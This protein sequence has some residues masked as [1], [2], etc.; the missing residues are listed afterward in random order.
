M[1]RRTKSVIRGRLRHR[2][3][4]VLKSSRHL[5]PAVGPAV[6]TGSLRRGSHG[7]HRWEHLRIRAPTRRSISVLANGKFLSTA[8]R[9]DGGGLARLVSA[10]PDVS[11][12]RVFGLNRNTGSAASRTAA[13]DCHIIAPFEVLGPAGRGLQPPSNSALSTICQ[14]HSTAAIC[15]ERS[16]ACHGDRSWLGR[17]IIADRGGL[18]AYGRRQ[19]V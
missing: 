16:A 5:S 6:F 1:S 8:W 11:P 3:G 7:R 17:G 12:G 4:L 10:R 14:R 15:F 19:P 2:N 18:R 13:S 9:A